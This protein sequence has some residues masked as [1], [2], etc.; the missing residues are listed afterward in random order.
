M[1]NKEVISETAD[2]VKSKMEG[3]GT[4]HDWW[5]IW[6]VWRMA[7]RIGEIEG[8]DMF[9]IELGALLHDIADWKF[10][11][12]DLK[13]GSRVTEDWLS[14]LGVEKEIIEH[15]KHIVENVSYKG[16]A[17]ENKMK[18]LEGF[19]VQ[20]ADRLDA[21][22]AIGLARTF[23]YGGGMNREIYNPNIKPVKNMTFEMYKKNK[24]TTINHFYE[25]SLLLKDRMNTET[26]R[27]IAEHRHKFM[28]EF[29][30]E[31]YA[32]WDGNR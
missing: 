13:A 2:F 31:F 25:K 16:D 32:E 1:K 4:G 20:D 21:I 3:D 9:V 14:R 29:L 11:D 17:E 6:R 15:V 27:M 22:G 18:T 7:K 19:I 8:G 28:E 24:G 5:H 10:N 23:A 26:A 30:E 12:G